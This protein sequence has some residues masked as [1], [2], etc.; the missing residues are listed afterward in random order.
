MPAQL[1]A[2]FNY[3]DLNSLNALKQSARKDD[4]E[5]LRAVA[6]QFESMYM[7]MVMA[8]MREANDVLRS[9]LMNSYQTDFY[10]DMYDEQLTLSLSQ[11]GG[12]GIAEVLYRQLMGNDA[13]TEEFEP[14]PL[15][16]SSRPVI[17]SLDYSQLTESQFFEDANSIEQQPVTEAK[18]FNLSFSSPKDFI[19]QL[20]PLAKRAAE[21]IGVSAKVLV[22]QAALETGWGQSQ[23]ETESGD[24]SF[25]F[26]G[27]KAGNGWQGESASTMTTEYIDGRA[28]KVKE[29]FRAYKNA[30]QSFND[31]AEFITGNRRY[32]QAVANAGN[33]AEY[34]N[35]LQ[36]A[37]YATDPN[38]ADK[39]LRIS[40]SEW[41]DEV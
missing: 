33:D 21:I 1:D 3:N 2:A 16:E 37:G 39:I 40:Q 24:S 29:P 8:S 34:V 28:I 25:N 30:E 18:P 4:P 31:Y 17:P 20:L 32:E 23:I 5:A 11:Q 6:Q 12:F 27:I 41:F 13:N 26:F 9:D 10:R 22:A 15:S 38:Y 35:A 36:K 14:K 7:D 19:E